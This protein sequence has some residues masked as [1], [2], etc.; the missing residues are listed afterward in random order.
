MY[1]RAYTYIQVSAAYRIYCG[2]RWCFS[3]C[4]YV[5][6]V[7]C[8]LFFL[9]LQTQLSWATLSQEAKKHPYTPSSQ[10]KG[11]LSNFKPGAVAKQDLSVNFIGSSCVLSSPCRSIAKMAENAVVKLSCLKSSLQRKYERTLNHFIRMSRLRE[12]PTPFALCKCQSNGEASCQSFG[13]TE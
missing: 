1:K 11:I 10:L 12:K 6:L 5:E 7:L 13:E 9:K 3:G 2:S 8:L 4:F